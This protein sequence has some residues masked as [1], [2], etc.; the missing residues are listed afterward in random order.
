MK[1]RISIFLLFLASNLMGMIHPIPL[2]NRINDCKGIALATLNHHVSYWDDDHHNIYTL[3]VLDVKAYLKGELRTSQIALIGRGGIVGFDKQITHPSINFQHD[4]DYMVFFGPE[5]HK[6]DFSEYRTFNPNL[7]Q[8]R[9][10]A[11]IQGVLAKTQDRYFD[12]ANETYLSEID[13][14]KKIESLTGFKAIKADGT[15]WQARTKNQA[16]YFPLR[17]IS[18]INNGAMT[19]PAFYIAGT[20]ESDNDL[21]ISGSGFGAAPGTV[22]FPN[23]DD[24]GA[25]LVASS[26]AAD[27]VSWSDTQIRIKIPSN[28]GTGNIFVLDSGSIL[29]GT[30]GI[31]IQYSAYNV[32]SDFF[33]FPEPT[34]QFPALADLNSAGGYTLTYNN[35][36][37]NGSSDFAGDTDA[38]DAFERALDSWRCATGVN[39]SIDATSTSLDIADD[40]VNVVSY[41]NLAAGTLG[42]TTSRYTAFTDGSCTYWFLEEVDMEF[43]TTTNWHFDQ[44]PPAF[45]E[46]DFETVALHELGHAHGLDH[47]INSAAVMHYILLN[48]ETKRTLG[49]PSLNGGAYVVGKSTM[50][51]CLSGPGVPPQMTSVSTTS[52]G[53]SC[54]LPIELVTFEG[55]KKGS[56]IFLYWS[57]AFEFDNRS[58]IIERSSDAKSFQH[59]GTKA[60]FGNS[61]T[62]QSYAFEDKNPL[63]G[64]NYYRLT[65]QDYDGK[66]EIVGIVLV[67]NPSPKG[68]LLIAQNPIQNNQLQLFYNTEKAEQL[69]LTIISSNGII[70]HTQSE[71]ATNGQNNWTINL[72]NLPPGYYFLQ[73]RSEE[74]SNTQKFLKQ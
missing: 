5:E 67:E 26:C 28:A 2:E 9:P 15:P 38:T 22:F 68:N 21:I 3:Y 24:G 52:D 18:S 70:L 7:P 11:G 65:Q 27:L 56:S 31:T 58:F 36:T 12:I 53:S 40:D 69:Q 43:S 48:Q 10:Y 57:T 14:V 60:G 51:P 20:I 72:Q 35:D 42:L 55:E 17:A 4:T 64:N 59:I 37:P 74:H 50:A 30:S 13:F 54:A 46:F 47:I 62:L 6:L 49:T 33:G 25:S 41:S 32:C 8:L 73:Y 63:T 1:I 44:T 66:E 29:V 23:A 61:N 19:N 45:T 39:F 16:S 34:R 71:T